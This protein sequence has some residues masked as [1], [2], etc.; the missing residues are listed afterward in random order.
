MI[1]HFLKRKKQPVE[2]F[3]DALPEQILYQNRT[4]GLRIK[5]VDRKWWIRY[6]TSVYTPTKH[7]KMKNGNIM[8][9]TYDSVGEGKSLSLLYA[10]KQMKKWLMSNDIIPYE[11]R[12][13]FP[14]KR[15]APVS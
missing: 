9:K 14:P 6:V 2:E 7:K 3:L 4:W 11:P 15:K 1:F 13:S 12:E 8:K 10:A 5:R